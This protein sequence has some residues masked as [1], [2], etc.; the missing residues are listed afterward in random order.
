[1]RLLS[2]KR[3]LPLN[4]DGPMPEPI[5][6][7]KTLYEFE[8]HLV[9]YSTIRQIEILFDSAD[10]LCDETYQPNASGSRRTLTEKYYH[11]LDTSK[12]EDA[13]KLLNVFEECLNRLQVRLNDP[14]IDGQWHDEDQKEMDRLKLR[15]KHDGFMF[16]DDRIVTVGQVPSLT[17]LESIAVT[18]DFPYLLRQ[19]ERIEA[20]I[21]AD[22]WLAIGTAK[23]LVETVCKTILNDLSKP[24]DAKWELMDLCKEARKEL[25]LTPDDIPNTNRAAETVK[26]L[27]SNLA[28]IVQGLAELRNPY[29]TGHGHEGRAKGL[30]PRHAR[31]AAGA[32]STLALF[33]LETHQ[34]AK[35]VEILPPSS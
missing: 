34:D 2:E 31:L 7:K 11:T 1:M 14:Q 17:H 25:K 20:S 9:K 24:I 16:K 6:S 35:A 18:A 30:K 3:T 28:T 10:V 29:G 4:A 12:W 21:D 26:R 27:L 22:P 8:E 33:L 32:A 23:E 15:L 5:I 19:L 13:K